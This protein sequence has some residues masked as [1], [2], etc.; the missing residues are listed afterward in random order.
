MN[1]PSLFFFFIAVFMVAC[2]VP[3]ESRTLKRATKEL[4]NSPVVLEGYLDTPFAGVFL[5]LRENGTFEHTTSGLL[6][7]FQAGNWNRTGDSI[8]L[9][10]LDI[11]KEVMETRMVIVDQKSSSLVFAGDT[12]TRPLRYRIV[13]MK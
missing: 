11:K 9:S 1:R 3:K 6:R 7:T 12:T 8:S 2:T 13:L 5:I 4:R 10:Y